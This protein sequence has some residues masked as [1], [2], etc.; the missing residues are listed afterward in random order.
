MI[1]PLYKAALIAGMN[2][3]T[4]GQDGGG[5]SSLGVKNM[6]QEAATKELIS[7]DRENCAMWVKEYIDKY[8]EPQGRCGLKQ[9]LT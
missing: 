1:C 7:C 2:A 4:D 3:W 6:L 5:L 9:C 8:G